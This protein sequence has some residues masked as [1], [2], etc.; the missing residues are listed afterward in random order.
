MKAVHNIAI[1]YELT[2]EV[3][4]EARMGCGMGA[5]LGCVVCCCDERG[6]AQNLRAC[7]DG[8]VMDSRRIDWNIAPV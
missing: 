7:I 5:C 1:Q 4:L 3:S 8:P 6:D 2:C